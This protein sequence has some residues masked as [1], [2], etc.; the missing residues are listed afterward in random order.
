MEQGGD[1]CLCVNEKEREEWE[2]VG[3]KKQHVFQFGTG[4]VSGLVAAVELLCSVL[5]AAFDL[6]V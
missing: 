1:R 2:V 5:S 4:S 3:E 6:L